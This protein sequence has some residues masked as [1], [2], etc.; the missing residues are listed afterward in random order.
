MSGKT[1]H[2]AT[3]DYLDALRAHGAPANT[4]KQHRSVLMRLCRLYP[5]RQYAGIITQ[6]LAQYLY[7]PKG[8]TVGKGGSVGTGARAA[9]RSFFSYGHLMGWGRPVTVPQ[10]VLRQRSRRATRGLPTRLTAPQLSLM[11]SSAND[12]VVRIMLAIAMNTGMRISDIIALP[13]AGVSVQDG[14]V[15][16][17]SQK[18]GWADTLPFT[19]D[20]QQEMRRYLTWY[21]KELG[22][23]AYLIPGLKR[24][25]PP[26][27]PGPKF[28]ADPNRKVSYSWASYRLH[29]VLEDCGIRVQDGEAWHVI[30][31]SVARIYFDSMR[32]EISYDHALRQTAA[33]LGHKSTTTTE[34]YL[35]LSTEIAAR[36]ESL[37]GKRF[38]GAATAGNVLPMQRRG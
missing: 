27:A 29:E 20:L 8:I 24:I 6:D 2:T 28:A 25:A 26:L 38:I 1:L 21:S 13:R 5:R 12:P 14:E 18:T 17:V 19:A 34:G 30:R 23:G 32:G 36:N 4:I 15:S 22:P 7:G 3:L 37:R 11:L 9:L 33:L 31:R 10:P 35:G 16:F